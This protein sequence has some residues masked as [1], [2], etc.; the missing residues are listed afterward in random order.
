VS[1]L[2]ATTVVPYA[3][4]EAFGSDADEIYPSPST[5]KGAINTDGGHS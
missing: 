1:V 3:A 2:V 4:G 5:P